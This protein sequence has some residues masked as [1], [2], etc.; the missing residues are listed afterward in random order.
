MRLM[1]DILSTL[2]DN[3]ALRVRERDQRKQDTEAALSLPAHW[4]RAYGP[5]TTAGQAAESSPMLVII[6]RTCR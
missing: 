2:V 3:V 6:G 4:K 1:F 5:P